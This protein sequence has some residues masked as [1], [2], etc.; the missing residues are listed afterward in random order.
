MVFIF[1]RYLFVILLNLNVI[2]SPATLSS[3]FEALGRHN[4]WFQYDNDDGQW[5]NGLNPL[6]VYSL[7]LTIALGVANFTGYFFIM[8]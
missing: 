8:V 5:K 3:P 6:E 1:N 2:M 7:L 4:G